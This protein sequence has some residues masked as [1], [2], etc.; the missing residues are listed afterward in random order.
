MF[1]REHRDER[2]AA[3]EADLQVR[4]RRQIHK[5]AIHLAMLD[6]ILNFRIVLTVHQGK[7]NA[8]IQLLKG[9]QQRWN[10][11]VGDACKR[12]DAHKARMQ[13]MQFIHREFQFLAVRN[14]GTN[15]RQQM[16]P[17]RAER[18][19]RA[20]AVQ[21]LHPPFLFQIQDHAA[22]GRLRVPHLL[23]RKA[24]ASELHGF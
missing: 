21:Q 8:G 9:N 3:Q 15:R 22:Y 18:N 24:D 12:A 5:P 23:R 13:A 7:L 1:R 2:I 4:D 17:N 19:A 11:H 14:D 6:P 16:L 10:P 20:A